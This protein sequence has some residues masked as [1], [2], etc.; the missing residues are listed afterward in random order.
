[1]ELMDLPKMI[2]ARDGSDLYRSLGTHHASKSSSVTTPA[3]HRIR[4]A[5][6][7]M[8][9]TSLELLSPQPGAQPGEAVYIKLRLKPQPEETD[10]EGRQL[11][12]KDAVYEMR[13]MA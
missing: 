7:S 12:H 11:Q 6:P 9:T 5:R 8:A 3:S 13:R 2:V 4:Q 10:E 1:M